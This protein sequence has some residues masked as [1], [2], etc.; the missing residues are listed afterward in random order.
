MKNER[1]V[2]NLIEAFEKSAFTA[3]GIDKI[4]SLKRYIDSAIE[5]VRKQERDKVRS[6]LSEL[7]NS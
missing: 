5:Q 2:L 6:F 3:I 7:N 4:E 1:E